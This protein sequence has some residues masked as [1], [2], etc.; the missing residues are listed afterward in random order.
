MQAFLDTL[1][2]KV[3]PTE[4]RFFKPPKNGNPKA[5]NGRLIGQPASSKGIPFNFNNVFF[6]DDSIFITNNHADLET[7][8]PILAQHFQRLGM[9]VHMGSN[10]TKSKTEAM[11]FPSSL[12][13]AKK[14]TA[15]GSL[16]ANITLPNNQQIQF[17]H[18]FKYLGSVITTELNEDTEVKIHINKA[19]SILGIAKHFFNNKDIDIRTK[20]NIYSAFAINAALWGCESWNL[21]TRNKNQLES[22]HHSAIRRILNIKWQQVCDNRIRNKQVRFRFCNIPKIESFINKRTATYVGK[23]TRSSDNELPKKFL[24]AW[25]HQ[26]KKLGGQQLSCNNNFAR[27]ITAVLPNLLRE[28]QGLLF[29]DWIPTTRDES[30][31]MKHIDDYFEACKTIDDKKEDEEYGREYGGRDDAK[32]DENTQNSENTEN[33]ETAETAE[34]IVP[35]ATLTPYAPYP[36]APHV[37]P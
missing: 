30:E 12:K 20:Y 37:G 19:K 9:Q 32:K 6:V 17:T 10:N 31:W 2:T 13:E 26:P 35:H 21:S 28:K 11:F 4:F 8:M 34:P 15:E 14:L 29:K 24:G 33:T 5:I 23:V 7:L 1:K 27:A 36:R 22:F 3:K 25:M 16:P 18:S